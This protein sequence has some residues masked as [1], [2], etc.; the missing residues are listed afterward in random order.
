LEERCKALQ[1]GEF[2]LNGGKEKMKERIVRTTCGICQIGCGVLAYISEDRVVAV[3]GDPDHPLNRGKLC[4]KGMASLEYLYHPDRLRQPLKRIGKRGEGKWAAIGWDEASDIVS[5]KLI[6]NKERYGGE[7]VVFMRGAAKGLQDDYLTRFANVFGSPNITSMS[8]VCFV[9]RKLA[10][11]MTYGFYAVP[12][13]DY[14]PKCIIVWGENVSETLH[15]VH[16]R[17]KKAVENRAKL[18]V[19]DPYKN[20]IAEM[21]D[22][23][24]RIK[25]GSDLPL[26]LSML[27]VMIEESLYDPYFVEHHTVGFEELK[28]HVRKYS[29]E[30]VRNVTWVPPEVIKEIARVYARNKPACIQWGNGIDHNVTNFQTARA[31]CII[32]AIT[33]N[34][35]IPGGE[36][37]WS[38]PPILERG[39]PGFSLYELM[40]TEV[41]EKRIMGGERLLTGL[42]YALPQAVID[43]MITGN[44]YA[45]RCAFI[46]GCNPLL[47]YPNAKKVYQAL[48]NLDFLVVSDIFMTPTAFLADV[49]LPVT[50]YLEFDSIVSS[51][52]SLAVASVQQ[53]VTRI[54]DC[55]SD[56]E[57]LRD[58]GERMDLGEFFWKKEEEC[59]DFILKPVGITFDEFRRIAILEGTKQHRTYRQK[60]FETPSNKVELY[61]HRLKE[62]GFDPLPEWHEEVMEDSGLKEPNEK[63]PFIFTTWKRA[64]FRHSGGRQISSLRGINP[65]SLV[66]IHPEAAKKLGI[67]DGDPVCIE[68]EM[69]KIIQKASMNGEI[70]PRM[71]GVDYGW[72]F[73]EKGPIS[74]FG[75]DESNTNVIIDDRG[76]YGREFGTPNLRG[77]I[78]KI[79]KAPS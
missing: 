38:P 72:W 59:L 34:I 22:L 27:H 60:G 73:P 32:R 47:S 53:R 55:R 2:H 58:L 45:I 6:E 9:P 25:P 52:Y 16:F 64:P 68:T 42:F 14:P 19:I 57:I 41:R 36:P 35:G 1:I 7:S 77:L 5:R 48:Q 76:P 33:G 11:T 4:P 21:A 62:W 23:W 56:Y 71:V 40:P 10:S 49:V 31:I 28:S 17:I 44:P 26:A 67:E 79:C 51:P 75:W 20:E 63:Y 65:E 24:V 18:I 39:S 30:K 50:T 8:H 29:P 66:M 12:D 15:H 13:L 74:N 46:Q 61:S 78:C 37:Q 54:Q 43:A 70:D 3:E 69:G